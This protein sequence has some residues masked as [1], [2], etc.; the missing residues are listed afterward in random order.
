MPAGI[1]GRSALNISDE[2]L[3]T[4]LYA[5]RQQIKCDRRKTMSISKEWLGPVLGE[6]LRGLV[7]LL[8]HDGRRLARAGKMTSKAGRVFFSPV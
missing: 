6:Y 5:K 7:V 3:N 4:L 2:A 1:L 8:L